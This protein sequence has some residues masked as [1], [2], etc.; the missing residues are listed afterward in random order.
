MKKLLFVVAVL[1][2]M[3]IAA[4]PAQAVKRNLDA[5]V[6]IAVFE[7]TGSPPVSGTSHYA[8]TIESS[9]GS[10]A[11]VGDNTFGPVPEFRGT[12]RAFYK[13]G[14]LKGKLEASGAVNP[15]GSV[16]FSGSGSIK[17]G[18]GKYKGA[19]G[20]FTLEGTQPAD[21]LFATFEIDGKVKY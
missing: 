9:I 2:V 13:K 7:I 1:A 10:G 3:A 14:T 16:S 17:N 12:F 19:K 20:R 15:D 21:S 18:T 4:A 11:I 6:D 5:T 8:G